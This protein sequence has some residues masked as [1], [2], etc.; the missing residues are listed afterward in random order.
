[1]YLRVDDT[2]TQFPRVVGYESMTG[3]NDNLTGPFPTATQATS[4]ATWQ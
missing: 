4:G 3:I 1:M 2:H